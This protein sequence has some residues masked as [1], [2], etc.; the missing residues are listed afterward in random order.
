[1][2][3]LSVQ[4]PGGAGPGA[5][6]FAALVSRNDHQFPLKGDHMNMWR[7]RVQLPSVLLWAA[8]VLLTLV[9]SLCRADDGD[10]EILKPPCRGLMIRDCNGRPPMPF[11]DS[12]VVQVGW[13][14]LERA[15]QQF[16]GPGWSKIERIRQFGLKIRL[17]VLAGVHAPSFVKGIGGPGISDPEHGIDCSEGG[18]AIWNR[19]DQRGG[20]V[21]RFWLPEVLDQYEELM[22][23]VAR[24]YEAAPDIC[25]VVNSGCMTL[26]AE[27]FY[28]AHVDT[29]TNLRLFEAGLTFEKDREAHRR[30]LL[31]HDRLFRC[32]RTA[33][34]INAWDM[35][36]DSPS[37]QR[38]S[39]EP[40]YELVTWARELMGERLVLQNNGTG[41]EAGWPENATPRTN[42]FCF[43]SSISGPRGFQTRTLSRLGG[44]QA[45]LG[46]TLE[47]TLKMGGNFVEL[48]SGFQHFDADWLEEFDRRLEA[49][50]LDARGVE[51]L[52]PAKS[53]ARPKQTHS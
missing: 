3:L 14:D 43:L 42:H 7:L 8:L 2:L 29:A 6:F 35:I 45:G 25:E 37:H 11:I 20:C 30:A 27:P 52:T 53:P 39:F 49:M 10:T 9:D 13:K 41:L 34:A 12:V 46:D 33:L 18:I 40:T 32:T 47:R 36:D 21:S 4:L 38:A 16:D 28:R 5:P 51:Q 22:I 24:R 19:W 17:R 15:D 50:P 44:A 1:M 31:I 23:E 26:Y 48:P